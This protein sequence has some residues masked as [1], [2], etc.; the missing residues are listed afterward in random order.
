MVN[1]RTG[2]TVTMLRDGTVYN[3]K[4]KECRD[5][6]I[7]HRD[8]HLLAEGMA[9]TMLLRIAR[10]DLY[11]HS[12]LPDLPFDLNEARASLDLPEWNPDEENQQNR[13]SMTE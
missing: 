12:T 9:V 2:N 13:E 5:H 11:Q 7:E 10:P 8:Q 3:I 4:R 6:L 1:T